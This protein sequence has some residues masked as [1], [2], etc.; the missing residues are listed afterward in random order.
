[1]KTFGTTARA[2]GLDRL[3]L[4]TPLSEPPS[5]RVR[6]IVQTED[7]EPTTLRPVVDFVPALG[8]AYR[9]LS[10]G[11]SLTPLLSR[12]SMPRSPSNVADD[13]NVCS[14]N[15]SDLCQRNLPC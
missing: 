9:D 15:P 8:S 10:S 6:V 4:D 7:D 3:I 1:M 2:E 14:L 11:A 5:G 12:P 13:W